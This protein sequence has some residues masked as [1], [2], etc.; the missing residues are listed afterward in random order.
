M[1]K[2][3]AYIFSG[4]TMGGI[5]V[6]IGVKVL[7]LL[8]VAYTA[9]SAS[10]RSYTTGD[11]ILSPER[12]YLGI[13]L[14]PRDSLEC[15]E[16]VTLLKEGYTLSLDSVYYINTPAADGMPGKHIRIANISLRK[17]GE[18]VKISNVTQGDFFYYNKTT[19]GREYRIIETKVDGIFDAEGICSVF[20][21]V[22]RP[23][24]Q[25]SDGTVE[26]KIPA[27][28]TGPSPSEEWNRTFGRNNEDAIMSVQQTGD[29]GYFL[30]RSTPGSIWLNKTDPSGN[31]QWNK[32]IFEY[33]A[34]VHSIQPTEDDGFAVAGEII[35]TSDGDLDAWLVKIDSNGRQQWSTKYG[36]EEYRETAYSVSQTQDGGYVL[37]G[38]IGI[39]GQG[40]WLIR[41]DQNGSEKWSR[42][43]GRTTSIYDMISSIHQTSDG[44]YIIA[45]KTDSE[46][47][48]YDAK[49]IKLDSNGS[50][51][52]NRTYGGKYDDFFSSV[53]QTSDGGY[54][55]AGMTELYGHDAWLIKMSPDGS[56]QWN[57]TFYVAGGSEALDVKQTLDGYILA[58][59]RFSYEGN[60]ALL[61]K[62]DSN[63]SE[64]WKKIF[65]GEGDDEIDYAQQ[66][67]DGGYI[68]A[69]TTKSYGSGNKDAW[70]IKVSDKPNR[71]TNPSTASPTKTLTAVPTEIHKVRSGEKATGFEVFLA[72]T[73]L[74]LVIAIT[75]NRRN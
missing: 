61:I 16:N 26:L 37:A 44:G 13:P 45:K 43:L 5:R 24:Y 67:W 50:E 42:T 38:S 6:L 69:G 4:N 8:L 53:R 15:H 27:S 10:Y 40:I 39:Y 62:T 7:V 46:F 35:R 74:L 54:I 75:R 22:L 3:G 41:T 60:D 48:Y 68:L 57:R 23:F 47:P 18:V 32:T 66:T 28:I 19:D 34:Q 2:G 56:E 25:Y 51:Q 58:G 31:E 30:A 70:L 59:R 73:T 36:E 21:V 17:N 71:T 20:L 12:I 11:L 9:S 65:G 72:I 49:F 33:G 52:W 64:M 1:F 63:G 55:L 29:G 14:D